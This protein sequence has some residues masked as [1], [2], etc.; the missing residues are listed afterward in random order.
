MFRRKKTERP[1][2]A[3]EESLERAEA[4]AAKQRDALAAELPLRRTLADI[5]AK[6][7]LAE[8]LYQVLSQRRTEGRGGT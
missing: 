8:E 7:H 3:A 2:R 6:N 1:S 5:R 4:D